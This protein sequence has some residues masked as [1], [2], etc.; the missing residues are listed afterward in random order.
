MYQAS[1]LYTCHPR[2]LL[3]LPWAAWTRSSHWPLA[4]CGAAPKAAGLGR[5]RP[6][7]LPYGVAHPWLQSPFGLP[8]AVSAMFRPSLTPTPPGWAVCTRS[9]CRKAWPMVAFSFRPVHPCERHVPPLPHAHYP[10][11]PQV[12]MLLRLITSC[13]VQRREDFFFPFIMVRGTA[14]TWTWVAGYVISG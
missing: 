1:V 12:V 8:A 4:L 5:L 11:P 6:E 2:V 7:P 10:I 9:P 3:H 13:E 14:R